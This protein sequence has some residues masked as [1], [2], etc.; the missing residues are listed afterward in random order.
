MLYAIFNF[1]MVGKN[2]ENHLHRLSGLD[3]SIQALIPQSC[4][5][6]KA[7][8]VFKLGL[9]GLKQPLVFHSVCVCV[10]VCLNLSV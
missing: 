8:E 7:T 9:S 1:L 6:H 2:S 4:K 5:A 3:L 10:S